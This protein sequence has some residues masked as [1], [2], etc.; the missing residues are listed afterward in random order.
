MP[1]SE[2]DSISQETLS[3][4]A[5]L[6]FAIDREP[7]RDAYVTIRSGQIVAVSQQRP[8]GP[9]H[10][11]GDA[12]LMPGLINAHTHLEFQNCPQPLGMAGNSFADWIRAVIDD[13]RR[14]VDSDACATSREACIRNGIEESIASG[15]SAIGEIATGD[16]ES[17][18]YATPNIHATVFHELIAPTESRIASSLSLAGEQIR[19]ARSS[20]LRLEVGLSPHTPYT[21]HPQLVQ[22]IADWC[23]ADQMSL[24]IHLAESTE[25]LRLLSHG[26]G[27]LVDLLKELGA[28]DGEAIPRGSKPLDYMRQVMAAPRVLLIH[29]N[30]LDGAEIDFVAEH[31]AT[32]SIIYCPRTHDYFGHAPYPLAAMIKAGVRVALGTDSRASNPDLSLW[33]EVKYVSEQHPD[34]TGEQLLR[35]AT[36][37][38]AESLGIAQTHGSIRSGKLADLAVIDLTG[39]SGSDPYERLFKNGSQPRRVLGLCT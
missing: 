4:R 5:Q 8:D 17:S 29:G 32:M 2:S 39:S 15:V 36:L 27:P 11:L 25:E 33:S 14:R 10:D 31:R 23:R 34:V 30:Y 22:E 19:R 26:D 9:V 20:D 18:P 35:I 6:V 1:S 38:G 21:V 16:W 12:A 13:R 28:W 24:A 37:N 7:L 3:L